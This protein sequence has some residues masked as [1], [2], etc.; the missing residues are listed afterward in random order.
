MIRT[1]GQNRIIT[2]R[3]TAGAEGPKSVVN[4]MTGRIRGWYPARPAPDVPKRRREEVR[5]R[6][7]GVCWRWRED[8]AKGAGVDQAAEA[9]PPSVQ[10]KRPD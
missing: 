3:Q 7:D 8:T 10:P 1:S 6:F 2:A 4:V 9:E 5:R